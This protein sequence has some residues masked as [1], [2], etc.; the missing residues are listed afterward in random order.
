MV[1]FDYRKMIRKILLAIVTM[2]V[3]F[4]VIGAWIWRPIAATHP[5]LLKSDLPPMLPLGEFYANQEW[6]WGYTVSRDGSKLAWIEIKWFDRVLMVKDL[7]SATVSQI[8]MP[9]FN[10]WRYYWAP[11]GNSLLLNVDR[12][13]SENFE[14]AILD[15]G[16]KD[17]EWR[18]FDLGSNTRSIVHQIPRKK[19]DEILI[20]SN[21]NNPAISDL[22][23]LNLKTG[24]TE[25][26]GVEPERQVTYVFDYESKLFGRTIFGQTG[27]G[28][29]IFETGNTEAGFSE[30][31]R[32][33]Y[34]D[35]LNIFGTVTEDQ[36]IYAISNRGRNTNAFVKLNLTDGSEEVIFEDDRV[37]VGW[38]YI[39]PATNELQMI[40][41]YPGAVEHKFY[42]AN[43]EALTKLLGAT[44]D[45]EINLRSASIDYS[46][47]VFRIN[48]PLFGHKTYLVDANQKTA[49]LLTTTPIERYKDSLS[50][51]E[52]VFFNA[53]DGQE[54]PAFLS[55][56]KGVEG[57]APLVII[58]HGGPIS[59]TYGGGFRSLYAVF[60]NRGYAV[61]D[62]NYRG[63]WGYGRR[64]AEAGK[65]EI[66][67]RMSSD[68]ID[69]RQWAVEQGIADPDAVGI[70]GISWGGFEVMTALTQ[71]S[72]LFAAGVNI[73]GVLKKCRTIGAVG[74]NG[75]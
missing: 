42:D 44:D 62:V 20:R 72:D 32:G 41:S 7:A 51:A 60:N 12:T 70:Y 2:L 5:A 59:R 43:F 63:S 48:E 24:K 69:A 39:N 74:K 65:D 4:A 56:P 6:K 31:A 38:V 11:D 61:L 53:R 45:A 10:S 66:A 18:Y 9:K 35:N 26:V 73:N 46:K 14:I 47:L 13:G 22:Y 8:E 28:D 21:Q 1:L 36:K 3:I 67:G 64:F 75:W 58:V 17:D 15:L 40:R 34:S 54:V 25:P 37:D 33:N 30:I 50:I 52:P 49:E 57:P 27:S 23:R 19:S 29:W 55:R 71:N 68:I 16:K